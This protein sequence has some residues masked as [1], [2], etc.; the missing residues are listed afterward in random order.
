MPETE[1]KPLNW[2][3]TPGIGY[4]VVRRPDGGMQV[5]FTDVTH[6]TLQHWREFALTHLLESDRLTTNLYD[7]RAI[8]DLPGEA[9]QF[10]LEVNSDPSVRNLRLA[11]V[12]ATLRVLQEVQEIAALTPGGVELNIFTDLHEAEAWLSRPLTLVK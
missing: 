2:A 3:P 7:L 1:I 6:A 10:A 12:V 9:I 4:V 5:T 11:V 8:P